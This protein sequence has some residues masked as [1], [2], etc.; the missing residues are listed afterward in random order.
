MRYVA[1]ES[2][3]SIVSHFHLCQPI[4]NWKETN[5][6]LFGCTHIRLH[7]SLTCHLDKI[8]KLVGIDSNHLLYSGTAFPLYQMVLGH[9]SLQLA[10]YMIHHDGSKL[11]S[12]S[13]QAA[14]SLALDKTLKYC[15]KCVE[16]SLKSRGRFVW[17]TEHQLYGVNWCNKHQQV[18]AYIPTGEGGSNRQYVLPE[19]GNATHNSLLNNKQQYFSN[20]IVELYRVLCFFSPISELSNY[21]REWLDVKGYLTKCGHIRAKAIRRDLY[22]FWEALVDAEHVILPLELLNFNYVPQLLHSDVPKH[23]LKHVMLM[24]FLTP[25]PKTFFDIIFRENSINHAKANNRKLLN[26]NLILS[27]LKGGCSMRQVAESTGYSVSA[28]KQVALRNGIEI[29]RRRQ[30]ISADMERD[31]WRKGFVGMHRQIIADFHCISV[32]AVEQIIQSHSGLSAWRKHLRFQDKLYFNRNAMS[33]F[34][35]Q[36]TDYSRNKLKHE[37]SSYMW[38]Y[39]HDNEW[40]YSHLPQAQSSKYHPSVDWSARDKIL[41]VK[42]E[43]MLTPCESISALDRQLGGHHWLT[44]YAAQLPLSMKAVQLKLI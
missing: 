40:L 44:K 18:L 25:D 37:C 20:F 39:K 23:Y 19:K 42:I 6:S 2:A 5:K 30:R 16:E 4:N 11:A 28:I 38:L 35:C 43:F 26:E 33:E 8:S 41:A 27:Q 14:F 31:I 36:H 1:G 9:E 29:D 12:I 24:A 17:L 13:K 10:D 32:G 34:I 22:H 21:Y 15:P 7:P 3:Y